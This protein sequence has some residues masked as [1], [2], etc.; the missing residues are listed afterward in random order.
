[1]DDPSTQ[2]EGHTRSAGMKPKVDHMVEKPQIGSIKGSAKLSF[3]S[4]NLPIETQ[5]GS[6]QASIDAKSALWAKARVGLGPN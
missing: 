5:K 6:E 4:S 1:M 3:P 2:L